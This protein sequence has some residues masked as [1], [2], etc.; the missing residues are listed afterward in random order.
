MNETLTIPNIEL[1]EN[2]RKLTGAH[3]T[4]NVLADFVATEIIKC[5]PKNNK[6]DLSIIDPASGDGELL[7]SLSSKLRSLGKN[8]S[9]AGFDINQEA[10]R[11]TKC[12]FDNFFPN[13]KLTLNH[14][15]FLEFVLD[16]MPY[17]NFDSHT[18]YNLFE[19]KKSVLQSYDVAISNPPYIRTQNLGADISQRL[20]NQFSLQGRT[21]IY[22]A[23]I[24]ALSCVL[25][26]GGVLGIIVSNRFM[27][28][29][30]GASIR[31][32]I[33][34]F[35]D[36]LHVWD[37]GDSKIFD[38][39]VLPAVLLLRKK[40][41]KAL[42]KKMR[43]TSIYSVSPSEGSIGSQN[44]ITALKKT[45]VVSLLDGRSFKVKQGS[46]D[47]SD[48][49]WRIKTNASQQFVN[50][51][52]KS[53][54][55]TFSDIGKIRVGIKTTADDV[56]LRNDWESII[57]NNN[58]KLLLPVTTHHIARRYKALSDKG[59]K[60]L[61]TH[62][63]RKNKKISV[64]LNRFPTEK[65]Y[66]YKHY[67]R[68][69]GRKYLHDAGRQW[70]E[71]WVPQDPSKWSQPKIIFRDIT[72]KPTFWIDFDK[73]VVN[74][75]CYWFT[76]EKTPD[77]NLLWLALA[78]GNSTFIESYYDACFNNKLYSGRRRFMSQYVAKFPLPDP[79]STISK[80]IIQKTKALF[81]C[82]GTKP[83]ELTDKIEKTVDKLV[84]KAFGFN[85]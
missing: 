33:P 17:R 74:G 20:S 18:Q 15:N 70:Y 75:D 68:L 85:R 79:R 69:N 50:A 78:V 72:K 80:N 22:Y 12:R 42:S 48:N 63:I 51:V 43:F 81:E 49:V 21:D 84:W 19:Q 34:G 9:L 60:V 76:T 23:F 2:E 61:Y 6:S 28:T 5:L 47:I 13:I 7:F 77:I 36:I 10:N 11:L 25:K 54:Y 27:T 35:F 66:L 37:L 40:G 39:A 83:I 67:D 14:Q 73:T 56:F 1:S 3:Y 62:E 31:N 82:V 55:C 57:P 8:F 46:L 29:Q 24:K 71:I 65:N 64:D 41:S 45:G 38:A 4:P 59:W 44:V 26:P 30:S 52:K 32:F 58:L 53:T 16:N